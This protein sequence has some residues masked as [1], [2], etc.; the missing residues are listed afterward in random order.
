VDVD[1]GAGA[2]IEVDRWS[3]GGTSSGTLGEH[4][5]ME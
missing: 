3:R 1:A 2:A 5:Q 4:Y